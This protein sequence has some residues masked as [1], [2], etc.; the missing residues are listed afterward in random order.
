M[1]KLC[2]VEENLMAIPFVKPNDCRHITLASWDRNA[3]GNMT[4]LLLELLNIK[5]IFLAI[6]L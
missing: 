6:F 5:Y 2:A 3:Y 1:I 4:T